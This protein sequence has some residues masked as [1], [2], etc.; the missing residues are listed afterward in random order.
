MAG[1]HLPPFPPPRWWETIL[2]AALEQDGT[3][4]PPFRVVRAERFRAI[5]AVDHRVALQVRI[6]WNRE[7]PTPPGTRLATR[8][9]WGTLV[10]AKRWLRG[11]PSGGRAEDGA[12][13]PSRPPRPEGLRPPSGRNDQP[14]VRE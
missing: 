12:P 11:A 6:A 8:R 7:A 1:E 2:R 14:T 10:G 9:T 5:V 3:A 4:G 13:G